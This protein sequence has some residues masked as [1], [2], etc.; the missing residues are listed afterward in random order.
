MSVGKMSVEI[1][2]D[3]SGALRSLDRV[4][5]KMKK[6]GEKMQVFGKKM[7][8]MVTLPVAGA[9]AGMAKS[10]MEL[11]ATEAKFYTVFGNMSDDADAF[12]DKFR[13]LTPATKAESRSLASSIQDLM[14]PMGIA[15]DE[16]TKMTG[17]FMHVTGAL[18]NFNS[19]THSA[20]DVAIAMQSALTGM[21][22]PL[23]G[24]GVQ[25]DKTTIQEI[26][27]KSG[28]ADTKEEITKAMEAQILLDEI[29]K[30]SGDALSAYTEENLDAKTKLLLL[31]SEVIDMAQ[32]YGARLLPGLNNIIDKMRALT[33]RFKN[34]SPEAQTLIMKI[35]A[36]A[37]AIGP[38][39][40]IVG[41][42]TAMFGFMLSPMGLVIAT[43]SLVALSLA[44]LWRT[45]EVFREIVTTAF[46]NVRDKAIQ[47]F[48][49]IKDFILQFIA[50][51]KAFWTEYGDSIVTTTR[52][53]FNAI[54]QNVSKFMTM[55]F[56]R[57]D[58]I[59]TSLKEL[60]AVVWGVIQDIWKKHGDTIITVV[61]TTF[62]VIKTVIK[63]ALDIV[64]DIIQAF[65]ALLSG[66]WETFWEEIFS[67]VKRIW[68]TIVDTVPTLL[69]NFDKAWRMGV[70]IL[71]DTGKAMMEGLWE[72]LKAIWEKIK[73]WID[74]SIGWLKEQVQ[75]WKK[76]TGE[77][78]EDPRLSGGN[79]RTGTGYGSAPTYSKDV[80]E[81]KYGKD[82][83]NAFAKEHDVDVG[84][85][86]G[87]MNSGNFTIN[88]TINAKT[89]VDEDEMRNIF[90]E[91]NARWSF[92][93]GT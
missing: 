74:D 69:E 39:I 55:I 88:N 27:L 91:N 53:K 7:T 70:D 85:A 84:T 23:K 46:Q 73:G 57:V 56:M 79:F 32:V 29:Y 83:I 17:E 5:A 75:F 1:N 9:F 68:D 3:E 51:F 31:K 50:D 20:E 62:E 81:D 48:T 76:E 52:D 12:L 54:W 67:I 87:M 44:E 60:F 45:S 36:V 34:L 38:V 92:E 71:K 26:A 22:R 66:D 77:M 28:M 30:Q 40:L 13:E 86:S 37:G 72:G 8:T 2:S 61:K 41:K 59:M 90:D 82:A 18:A 78:Q 10:A 42:L 65:T 16:A 35:M 25:L 63:T 93:L 4:S 6:V 58:K 80:A 33:E 47:I 49:N 21:Y 64:N 43:L 15:R 24:L 14:V 11:E 19:G 89:T